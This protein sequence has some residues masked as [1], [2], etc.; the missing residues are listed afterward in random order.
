VLTIRRAERD[1]LA[2][3]AALIEAAFAAG[4]APD[5]DIAGR[6]A[7]RMYAHE[8]A[9]W[10]RL[11]G[12]AF[13]LVACMAAEVVGYAELQGP[14]RELSG[15]DHLSLLFV[16]PAWQRRGIARRL[17][18]DIGVRLSCLP[19]APERLTVNAAPGAV[20][21]Y[22][23]LGFVATGPLAVRDGIRAVPMLLRLDWSAESMQA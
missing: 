17:I 21:A 16:A 4:V 11:D 5:Y 22:L 13:G 23:R 8:R 15:R 14:N 18:A 3:A 7:F 2:A 1:D 6:V 20:A 19:R 10:S 12:G 9:I